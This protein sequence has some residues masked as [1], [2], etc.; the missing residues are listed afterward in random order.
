MSSPLPRPRV[1]VVVLAAALLAAVVPGVVGRPAEAI[2]Q[3]AFSVGC[4]L[5]HTSRDDPIVYPG[6]PGAAHRHAFYG[7]RSTDAFST[8]RSLLRANSTCRHDADTAATWFPTA[9]FRGRAVEA[10]NERTYYFRPDRPM[11]TLP[12]DIKLIG[13]NHQAR[14]SQ[15]N[16]YVSWSCGRDTPERRHPYNCRPYRG[17]RGASTDGLVGR[18]DFPWC[19][20]GRLDSGDHM[21]HVIYPDDP[22]QCPASHDR[23]IPQLSIRAH[24]GIWDVCAGAR[25]CGPGSDGSNVAF[26]LSSGPYWTLHADFWNT[27]RQPALDRLIDR[28]LRRGVNCGVLGEARTAGYAPG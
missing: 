13:G 3:G 2:R 4:R 17:D 1:L 20:D 26:E 18:I 23:V 12:A 22:R 9:I 16:P 19:W 24:W 15:D 5:S 11:G 6:E 10:Q 7:N 21:S 8:R 25:P 14:R 28:C 27:W